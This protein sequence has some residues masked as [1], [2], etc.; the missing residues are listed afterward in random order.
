[1]GLP[2]SARKARQATC[3]LLNSLILARFTPLAEKAVEKTRARQAFP[4]ASQSTY[5]APKSP[6]GVVM[7]RNTTVASVLA[8]SALASMVFS[9]PIRAVGSRRSK[10]PDLAGALAGVAAWAAT[11][12]VAM[13]AARVAMRMTGP[14]VDSIGT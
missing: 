6:P 1:M 4:L 11:A 5:W 2:S 7:F 9:R 3:P 13:A 10:G 12:K 14:W 8:T